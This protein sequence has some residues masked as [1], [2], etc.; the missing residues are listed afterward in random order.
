MLS[1]VQIVQSWFGIQELSPWKRG[2]I[3]GVQPSIVH[4][5]SLPRLA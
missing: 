5:N 1:E 4:T 2:L 3:S